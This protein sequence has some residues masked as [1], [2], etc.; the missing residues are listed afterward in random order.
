MLII[1]QFVSLKNNIFKWF[2]HILIKAIKKLNL[3]HLNWEKTYEWIFEF[4]NYTEIVKFKLFIRSWIKKCLF[5]EFLSN[6]FV[7][8]ICFK[9]LRIHH[10][11]VK[12]III[13]RHPE[14]HAS[15]H[16]NNPGTTL[17]STI[18]LED[19]GVDQ[20]I[21]WLWIITQLTVQWESFLINQ[22]NLY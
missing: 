4:C 14:S 19:T 8:K 3:F 12:L 17:F 9:I 21:F 11:L 7:E 2:S 15:F 18:R 20:V 6:K 16:V 5:E 13:N 10:I 1:I 22:Q